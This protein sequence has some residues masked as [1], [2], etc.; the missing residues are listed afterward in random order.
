M[1]DFEKYQD[2]IRKA[3]HHVS[4]TWHLDYDDV[5]AQGYLEYCEALERFD[6]TRAG[7]STYLTHRLYGRLNDYAKRQT[8]LRGATLPGME[9]DEFNSSWADSLESP[10]EHLSLSEL[11]CEAAK[12][13]SADAVDVLLWILDRK[14]EKHG[15]HIRPSVSRAQT[16]FHLECAWEGKRVASAWR[17]LSAWWPEAA[18]NF[19]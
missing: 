2:M 12:E 14:W 11:V 9:D 16:V 18:V 1:T 13:I 4:R 5:E 3:A 17:E 7:F 8:R 6:I 10:E 19:A 15:F